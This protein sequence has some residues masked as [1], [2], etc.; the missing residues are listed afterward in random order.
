[1]HG[2]V[3]VRN[4]DLAPAAA[5][6]TASLPGCDFDPVAPGVQA[7]RTWGDVAIA[8]LGALDLPFP[9][10]P[11]GAVPGPLHVSASG[12]GET[13]VGADLPVPWTVH[14]HDADA[15]VAD[16]FDGT[17]R[18]PR[19]RP[20]TAPALGI[21]PA[22]ARCFRY[23]QTVGAPEAGCRA[24]VNTATV[25]ASDSHLAASASAT[26]EVCR[27]ERATLELAK[28]ASRDVVAR[29]DDGALHPD[30]ARRPRRRR[31]GT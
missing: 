24:H 15:S 5:D 30:G 7:T 4:A 1:M 16:V 14:E 9:C 8:A 11:A 10:R 20:P 26:A 28:T 6:V 18:C 21:D 22:G 13:T 19:C 25:T 2:V 29:G 31:A 12:L 23:H 3:E 17:P 27:S